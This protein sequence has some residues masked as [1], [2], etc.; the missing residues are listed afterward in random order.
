MKLLGTGNGALQRA[1]ALEGARIVVFSI[2]AMGT[3][4]GFITCPMAGDCAKDDACYA[5]RGSYAWPGVK[6]AFLARLEVTRTGSFVQR[7]IDEVITAAKTARRNNQRLYVRVHD[8]GDFYNPAYLDKWLDIAKSSPDDVVFYAYTKSLP[9][10]RKAREAGKVPKN[11]VFTF[12]QGGK[13]DAT[14]DPGTEK[15]T[16]MFPD[17]ESLFKAGY[18]NA[19]KNDLV[20]AD[21]KVLKVGLIY[22]GGKTGAANW[23]LPWAGMKAYKAAKA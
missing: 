14:I 1:A 18:A 3:D 10:V 6:A 17:L 12:S 13:L 5:M 2:P 23:N 7:M 15:H 8:S 4:D 20:A 9:W 21:P 11:F 16:R 22:H 19:T